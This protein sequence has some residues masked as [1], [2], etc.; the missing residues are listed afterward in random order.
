MQL[1]IFT[2]PQQGASYHQLLRVAQ[3]AEHLGFDGFFRSDHYL[4]M[5]DA[6]G[7]PGPTDAWITLAGIARETSTIRLGTLVT[8]ATFRLPGPLAVAVAEVDSMSDGRVELGLGAGWFDAE[9]SAY[10]IPFPSLGER[11]ERLEE[12][13]SIIAGMW[14][15]PEGETF[16]FEGNHYRVIESPALP[17]PKQRPGPPIIIGGGG[18]T[19]TPRLA[20]SFA[21]E[22]NVPFA[23]GE[24]TK[25][26]YGRVRAACEQIGRDPASMAFSAAQVVCCGRT[27]SELRKRAEVIGRTLDDLRTHGLCGTPSE[28]VDRLGEL[29]GHG[30]QRTYLQFLALDDME[31][32]ELIADEVLSHCATLT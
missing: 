8:S 14:S 22:F 16:S 7:L 11:F 19:R 1:R 6:D 26:Q 10:G 24:D 4:A 20:A 32:L 5:G 9:H 25:A 31:H 2:E 17:K 18:K 12:Q 28:V 27:E 29:G 3:G 30:V 15:S 13:L 23:S 21:T